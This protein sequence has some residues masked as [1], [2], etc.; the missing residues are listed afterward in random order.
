MIYLASIIFGFSFMQLLVAFA[1]LLFRQSFSRSKHGFSGLV[2]VLIPARNEEKNIGNLLSDLLGQNYRQI[3][4]LVFNDLSTDNTASIVSS[5]SDR[6]SRVRLINSVVLPEGW[7]GKN[8]ACDALSKEAKGEYFL[9]LD[10]DVRVQNDLIGNTCGFAQ[11]H[12]LGLL[13]IFPKQIM[14]TLGE[15]ISVP[16]MNYILLSLL[17]LILVRKSGFS[18]MAAANGQCML[19]NASKYHETKPHERMKASKVED[20]S[21]ARYFKQNAIPVA[22]MTGDKTI[23]CRMYESLGE[24]IHGFSKN[25]IN[26]FGDSFVLAILF[27]LVTTFGFILIL[28]ALPASFL[29]A[30]VGI[31]L[32]TRIVISIVSNQSITMNLIFLIPQQLTL[33]LFVVKAIV[34]NI[35][36]EYQWKGRSI[37]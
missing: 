35:K 17:P 34:N 8:F 23:S 6:D 15:K 24:A 26:F 18:S 25:V 32:L 3:E 16:N 14:R 19:F 33:G 37:S 29:L 36:K 22:C 11:K 13:T 27:W 30:Y 1:N 31:I 5:F 9:F 28:F 4:I 7:L 20:I 12:K 2:S 10:A 21:I